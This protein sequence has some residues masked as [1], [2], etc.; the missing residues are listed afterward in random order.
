MDNKWKLRYN[1]RTEKLSYGG[2][3]IAFCDYDKRMAC[4]LKTGKKGCDWKSTHFEPN[5]LED[6]K[7][8]IERVHLGVGDREMRR[9]RRKIGILIIGLGR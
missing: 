4:G 2:I 7:T 5:F 1:N 8:H 6:I 9:R 3:G